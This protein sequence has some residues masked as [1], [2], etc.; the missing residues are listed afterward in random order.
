MPHAAVSD[1]QRNR[2]KSLRR[3]A[4][5]AE[6]L[7]WR[8]IKAGHLDGLQFRRQAPM[9]AYIVDFVCHA[10]ELVIEVDGDT[11]DF[12][13]RLKRDQ[14]RDRWLLS[15]GYKVLRFTNREIL[16]TLEGVLTIIHETATPRL[17]APPSLPSPGS[18]G[19][20]ECGTD[21][22]TLRRGI[23]RRESDS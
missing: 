18:G 12:E 4:T 11:N 22:A 14:V 20:G 10:A 7:L 9:G 1:R 17:E 13:S 8:Y 23:M 15:R 2:A 16:S 3:T 6:T 19:G 5:R 21:G